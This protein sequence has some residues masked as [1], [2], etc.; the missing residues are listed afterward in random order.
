MKLITSPRQMQCEAL[1]IKQSGKK[2]AF[3]P[4]M[5]AL[6]E[7]HLSL[8]KL[9]RNYSD[10]VVMSIYVNPTQF[11]L[12][13]DFKKYPRPSARDK[14][15][16]LEAGVTHLFRPKNLY[17]NDASTSITESTRSQGLCGAQRKGHFTGVATVVT[18]LLNIVQADYL[19]LGQKDA[20]QCAVLE[21]VVR[22]L[23]LPVKVVRAPIVRD[24]KGLA[25]SS[26]NT[27]LSEEEYRA[28]LMLSQALHRAVV[29]KTPEMVKKQVRIILK[30]QPLIKVEYVEVVEDRLCA[31]ILVGK[32]RLIDNVPLL[33]SRE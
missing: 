20:Q 25:L 10:V 19:I 22:D 23:Y 4:T 6:H 1:K 9:A 5:G 31:A 11:G 2:I 32:T 24:V 18:I 16:A 8:V 26:R 21:R 28:A 17:H 15:L 12:G 14:A 7:G 30:S 3:V 33:W 13:E 29:F 27:Y